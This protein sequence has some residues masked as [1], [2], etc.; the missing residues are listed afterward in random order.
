MPVNRDKIGPPDPFQPQSERMLKAYLIDLRAVL[1]QNG[2]VQRR[3]DHYRLR[4]REL[5]SASGFRVH[6]SLW[7]GRDPY[8]AGA[9][10]ALLRRW[11]DERKA[12]LAL[13][14]QRRV[15]EAKNKRQ[16]ELAQ[17]KK[18]LLLGLVSG[19][20]RDYIRKVM[21]EFDAAA[22]KGTW[23]AIQ[24]VNELSLQAPPRSGRKTGMC[25]W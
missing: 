5:D 1:E 16:Q 3:G 2:I 8:V 19:G 9:V 15:S 23:A 4:Y 10:A 25:L 24:F 7:I 13:A 20:G 6:R 22:A 21:R 12:R 17:A 11:K 18:K 14:E